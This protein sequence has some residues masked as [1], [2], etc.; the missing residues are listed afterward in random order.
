MPEK[1]VSY[2]GCQVLA[3]EGQ[4]N[5]LMTLKASLLIESSRHYSCSSL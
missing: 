4:V 3:L 5:R 2:D 1:V